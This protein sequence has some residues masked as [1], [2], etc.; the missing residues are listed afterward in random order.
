M[1]V[2][3][4]QNDL[5]PGEISQRL[6]EALNSGVSG[7]VL[8]VTSDI[9]YSKAI[10]E[11]E[12]PQLL[13][14][15]ENENFTLSVLSAVEDKTGKLDL[16]AP[17]Q[18]L[19]QP[20]DTLKGIK[21]FPVKTRTDRAKVAYAYA[22]RRVEAARPAVAGDTLT[23]E[24]QTRG[25]PVAAQANADLVVRIRPPLEHDRCPNYEG[26]K[27]LKP[28][29]ANFSQLLEIS[30]A[31]R[32]LV[33]GGAHLTVAYAMGAAMPITL[34]GPVDVKHQNGGVWRFQGHAQVPNEAERRLTVKSSNLPFTSNGPLLVYL[35]LLPEPS[36]YAY[37]EF[38]VQKDNRF[39]GAIHIRT[40]SGGSLTHEDTTHLIREI[41]QT[42]RG[43]VDKYNTSEVHLLLRCPWPVALLVGRTLNTLRVHL[44]EWNDRLGK[45]ENGSG[46]QYV[47][48]L[49]VRSGIGGSV[50]EK[51]YQP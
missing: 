8:L 50:L 31:K 26:L 21:Q 13:K 4:D 10:Q 45:S 25:H 32:I 15:A 17:D 11:V 20:A 34:L 38:C 48:T 1:P 29:L 2:W 12:L 36:D 47:P 51:I 23:I 42:I 19:N 44:Y 40:V 14:L 6:I 46:P 28:F 41:S 3:H 37:N 7:A 35:D 30:G 43:L 33:K 49:I 5:P 16:S 9:K 18:L 39:C 22:R 24:V 27:D